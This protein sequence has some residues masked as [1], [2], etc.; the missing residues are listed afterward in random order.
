DR[1]V[2]P[3]PCVGHAGRAALSA[4]AR[5][6]APRVTGER[7]AVR[8]ELLQHAGAGGAPPTD[9][10][11]VHP[12]DHLRSALM[13]FVTRLAAAAAAFC[14]SAAA[15]GAQGSLGLQGYGYPGGE[16]ST[17]ALATGGAL[18]DFDANSPINPAALMIGTR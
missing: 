2:P 5:A 7:A 8:G 1:H 3:A 18:G 4:A 14:W 6:R 9:A 11:F 17:R 10:D 16:L 12:E 15:L 13:R